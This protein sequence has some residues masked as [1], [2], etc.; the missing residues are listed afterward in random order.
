MNGNAPEVTVMIPR[1]LVTAAMAV[2]AVA[3]GASSRE[4]GYLYPILDPTEQ[5][6][7]EGVR[8]YDASNV[9]MACSYTSSG[10]ATQGMWWLGSLATGSGVTSKVAPQFPGQTV[11]TSLSYGPNTAFANPTLGSGTIEIVGSYKY[12]EARASPSSRTSRA[13][14]G[15]RVATTR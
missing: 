7:S 8:R 13:S 11:A 10:S 9:L 14:R 6:A 1:F 3:L 15:C 4:Q 5:Q 2:I 12:A